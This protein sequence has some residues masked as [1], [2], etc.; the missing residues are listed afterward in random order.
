METTESILEEVALGRRCGSLGYLNNFFSYLPGGY[1]RD[2]IPE[3]EF[4]LSFRKRYNGERHHH[5]DFFLSQSPRVFYATIDRVVAE[6]GFD[7]T[8]IEAMQEGDR[9]ELNDHT[10]TVYV[11]LRLLGYNHHDLTA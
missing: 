5:S 9:G 6:C 1:H 8:Q 10:L 2:I 11:Q 7:T 3:Q 4:D